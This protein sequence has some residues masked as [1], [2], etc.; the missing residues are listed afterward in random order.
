LTG[1]FKEIV[2]NNYLD[3]GFKEIIDDDCLNGEFKKIVDDD[4]RN[5]ENINKEIIIK[6]D[7]ILSTDCIESKLYVYPL[8]ESDESKNF[9]DLIIDENIIS[10]DIIDISD[11]DNINHNNY[12]NIIIQKEIIDKI[13]N[14]YKKINKELLFNNKNY[15]N[16]INDNFN[17]NIYIEKKNIL[18][19][20]KEICLILL[21]NTIWNHNKNIFKKELNLV[22]IN[23]NINNLDNDNSLK[24]N[25][26]K[27][28]SK[29]NIKRHFNKLFIFV[30]YHFNSNNFYDFSIFNN[31]YNIF[32]DNDYEI[33]F[34]YDSK[35]PNIFSKYDNVKLLEKMIFNIFC[36]NLEKFNIYDKIIIYANDYIYIDNI[37]DIISE[38]KNIK[39]LLKPYEQ[40]NIKSTKQIKFYYKYINNN[41]DNYNGIELPLPLINNYK[42]YKIFK[43]IKNIYIPFLSKKKYIFDNIVNDLFINDIARKY[44]HLN[45]YLDKSIATD[46]KNIFILNKPGIVLDNIDLIILPYFFTDISKIFIRGL[47]LGC[48]FLISDDDNDITYMIKKFSIGKTYYDEDSFHNNFASLNINFLCIKQNLINEYLDKWSPNYFF[49]KINEL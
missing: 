48:F 28:N 13:Y 9:N 2:D 42:K 32:N 8:L 47:S 10:S 21:Q 27:N 35:Y 44:S 25:S 19:H 17:E 6:N 36:K 7:D 34:L 46:Q 3:G 11:Y 39:I 24:N 22:N 20:K 12:T 31:I 49:N 1:E 15:Y 38:Y 5:N 4:Y 41:F 40:Y 23:N 45:F 26:K 29:K 30:D 14:L 43:K 33:W 16:K 18:F 37:I